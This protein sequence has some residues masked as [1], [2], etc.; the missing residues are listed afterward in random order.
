MP[1]TRSAS[2]RARRAAAAAGPP[3][4][5]QP[6]PDEAAAD[7]LTLLALP[8]ELLPEPLRHL[9]T[10]DLSSVDQLCHAFH[11]AAPGAQS[12]VEQAL[13]LR[14]AAAGHAVPEALGGEASWVQLLLWEERR[15]AAHR[16]QAVAAG[17]NH[18]VFVDRSGAVLTCG[19]EQWYTPGL[20]GHVAGLL[21]GALSCLI[22][23]QT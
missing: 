12:V 23:R 10:L 7:E 4:A 19:I 17:E 5:S 2:A 16:P 13:R 6:R 18:T 11:S 9:A 8:S 14:A 3:P 15:R 22:R 20:L 21:A 1:T